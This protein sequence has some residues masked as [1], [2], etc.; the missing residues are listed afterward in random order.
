MGLAKDVA[1]AHFQV[2][3]SFMHV[4]KEHYFGVGYL[5]Y[6]AIEVRETEAA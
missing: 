1:H 3:R 4:Y 5:L 6:Y 2:F